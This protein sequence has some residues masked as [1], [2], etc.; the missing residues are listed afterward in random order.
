MIESTDPDDDDVIN[1]FSPL[2]VTTTG[3]FS[4]LASF[5][6]YNK[7]NHPDDFVAYFTADSDPEF[8]ITP[9]NGELYS[10]SVGYSLFYI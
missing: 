9:K 5:K 1:V 10:V 6:L 7:N 8:S 4:N 3:N 2:N